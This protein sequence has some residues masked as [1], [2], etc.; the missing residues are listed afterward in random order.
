MT[1]ANAIRKGKSDLVH[2]AEQLKTKRGQVITDN[3]IRIAYSVVGAIVGFALAFSHNGSRP[4]Y[5][6][7]H[8]STN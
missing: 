1:A 8:S 3:L 6:R 5:R 2:Y 4:G 7:T